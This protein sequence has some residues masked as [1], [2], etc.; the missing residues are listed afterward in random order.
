M[1]VKKN[2]YISAELDWAEA[3]LKTWRDYIDANPINQLKDR[4]DFKETKTGGVIPMV[5][6][7]IEAQIKCIQDTMTKYL[8]LLEVIDKLREKEEQLKEAKSGA[9]IPFRMRNK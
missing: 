6:Q 5:V 3:Q 1:G 2:N 9:D 7:T 4:K 8:Q